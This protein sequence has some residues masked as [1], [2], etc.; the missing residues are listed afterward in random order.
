[1]KSGP[2]R[3][4]ADSLLRRSRPALART[5]QIP[6]LIVRVGLAVKSPS[7][8][9]LVG[10]VVWV[11]PIPS[12]ARDAAYDSTCSYPAYEPHLAETFG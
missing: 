10:F 5:A 9:Q 11:I 7:H 3:S 4:L 1:M 2:S 8:G 6:K 12:V